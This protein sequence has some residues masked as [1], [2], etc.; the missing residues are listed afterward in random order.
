MGEW[1]Q[2]QL[3]EFSD[4][5]LGELVCSP[6]NQSAAVYCCAATPAWQYNTI[7]SALA[8]QCAKNGR[9][10]TNDCSYSQPD[11]QNSGGV[12]RVSW[13]MLR[14]VQ[15]QTHLNSIGLITQTTYLDLLQKVLRKCIFVGIVR[16]PLE[17]QEC[18]DSVVLQKTRLRYR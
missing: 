1:P 18:F 5:G 8:L 2:L 11:V 17:R 15:V 3:S 4:R 6:T 12:E 7:H 13:S 14:M 10:P 9:I 16:H